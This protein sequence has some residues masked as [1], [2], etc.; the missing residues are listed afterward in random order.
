ME[1]ILK[2]VSARSDTVDIAGADG[3][4]DRSVPEG[5][6][7]H[8]DLV[9][10]AW[11]RERPEVDVEPQGLVGRVHRL[12]EALS[13]DIEP[14]FRSFGLA[15]GEFDVLA[16]LRRAGA[17]F[18]R[19]AGELADHTMVTSGAATKRVDRLERAGLV[20]RRR[21]SQDGRA[22]VI[23]LTRAG[24]ELTDRVLDAHMANEHRMLAVLSPAERADLERLLRVWISRRAAAQHGSPVTGPQDSDPTTDRRARL[25]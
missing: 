20:T 17:P 7:D 16:A 15:H 14:V 10:A 13:S 3:A 12:A 24:L 25:A 2:R 1:G 18:E 4:R 21:S 11:R 6:P 19:R 22:R 5:Y 8:V 23:A 9:Q